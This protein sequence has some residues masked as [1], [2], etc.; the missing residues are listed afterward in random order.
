MHMIRAAN[1]E[2]DR[3]DPLK[4]IQKLTEYFDFCYIR[5]KINIKN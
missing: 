2:I 5:T 1:D 4:K 3:S